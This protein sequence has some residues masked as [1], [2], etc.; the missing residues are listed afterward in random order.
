MGLTSQASA[1]GPFSKSCALG[2][3][4][5]LV[6]NGRDEFLKKNKIRQYFV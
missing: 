1:S 4:N 6:A 3:L 2:L 5:I